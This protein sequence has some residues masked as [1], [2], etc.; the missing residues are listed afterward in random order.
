MFFLKKIKQHGRTCAA[1]RMHK[2]Y[3]KIAC[4]KF[5]LER[6]YTYRKEHWASEGGK[7]NE[8]DLQTRWKENQQE[9]IG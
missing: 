4:Y 8:D 2:S 9:G 7:R 6:I 3:P 5:G 1:G